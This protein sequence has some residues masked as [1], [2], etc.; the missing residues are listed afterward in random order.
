MGVTWIVICV[1]VCVSYVYKMLEQCQA[2]I[3]HSVSVIVF[4][5]SFDWTRLAEDS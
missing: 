4:I 2:C 5:L 3:K 1:Y